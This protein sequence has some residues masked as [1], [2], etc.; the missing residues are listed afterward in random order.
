MPAARFCS[1]CGEK[2]KL[3][4]AVVFFLRSYCGRC[5]PRLARA[6]V[7]VLAIPILFLAIGFAIGNY[8]KS[9][10]PFQF[11]GAPIDTAMNTAASI[12]TA[13]VPAPGRGGSVARSNEVMN[14]P[15]TIETI[16][17]AMTKSGRPC[18]RKVKSGGRC[19]QHKDK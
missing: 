16:C 17:G 2:L 5:A 12:P 9:R 10:E 15:A 4:P 19:W 3:K 11:V 14:A 7:L 8:S 1:V 6:R 13:A 18:Q